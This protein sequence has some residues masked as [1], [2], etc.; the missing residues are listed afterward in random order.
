[1]THAWLCPV[2]FVSDHFEVIYDLDIEAQQNAKALGIKMLRAP[3][4]GSHPVFID[5]MHALVRENVQKLE[6]KAVGSLGPRVQPC[7]PGC[8]AA[9]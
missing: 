1:M 4:A 6:P 3:T 8:C 9:R 5:M 2:G 7:K